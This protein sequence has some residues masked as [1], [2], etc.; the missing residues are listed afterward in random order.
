MGVAE[1]LREF[2]ARHPWS[3]NE[4]FHPWILRNL[5]SGRKRAVDVG[6]GQGKL[7]VTLAPHFEHV[8]GTDVDKAMLAEASQRTEALS[9]V[10]VTSTPLA[11]LP[12][13]LDLV[14]MVAV[15][16]H[17]DVE[18]A[19]WRVRELLVPGGRFLAVGLAATRTPVDHVWDLASAVTNPV[20]GLLRHPRPRHEAVPDSVPTR[21]PALGVAE[22]RRALA[23][24][25]P[26]ARLRRRV[27]FRHTIEWTR[28]G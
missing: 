1:R 27:A 24:V 9:N 20:I 8:T 10:A 11:D 5:P 17:L 4:Y 19:L 18:Q 25:M 6:C 12:P 23:R 16:H 14:C 28:P 22:L 7:L 2:N 26:G 13:G 3:H 21:E 15:L